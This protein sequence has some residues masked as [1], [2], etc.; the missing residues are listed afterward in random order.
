MNFTTYIG[1]EIPMQSRITRIE[2][3]LDGSGRSL[4]AVGIDEALDAC[5]DLSSILDE[6]A[7]KRIHEKLEKYELYVGIFC[8][9][10]DRHSL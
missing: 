1:F 5:D 10:Y 4:T 7:Q 2:R 9:F 8:C 6:N 3:W